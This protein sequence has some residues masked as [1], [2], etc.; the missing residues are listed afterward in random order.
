M[1]VSAA[2]GSLDA[3]PT[4]AG[5]PGAFLAARVLIL[6]RAAFLPASTAELRRASP[7]LPFVAA[8]AVKSSW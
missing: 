4:V 5:S 2:A 7:S 3:R 8:S 6:R 1:R